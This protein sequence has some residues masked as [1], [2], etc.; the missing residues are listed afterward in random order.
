MKHRG[1]KKTLNQRIS[2]CSLPRQMVSTIRGTLDDGV[3][4]ID[5]IRA[6]FPGGSMTGAPKF[7]AMD[8][9]S[10]IEKHPRGV[11]SGSIGYFSLTGAVDLNIVIR[12]LVL[13]ETQSKGALIC[14]MFFSTTRLI[15]FLYKSSKGRHCFF[16][17]VSSPSVETFFH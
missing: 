14:R 9:I 15:N 13:M 5:A 8:I 7:R 6:C 17:I 11:Y 16:K 3:S 2:L 10:R 1:R 12:T 4:A